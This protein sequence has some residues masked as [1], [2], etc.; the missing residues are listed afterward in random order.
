[1]C[2]GAIGDEL[3]DGRPYAEIVEMAREYINNC[4]GFEGFAEWGLF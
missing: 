2:R 4:G 1:M 3:V